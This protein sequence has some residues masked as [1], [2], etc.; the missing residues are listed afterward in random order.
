[1]RNRDGVDGSHKFT[2]YIE[3]PSHFSTHSRSGEFF[4]TTARN[5]KWKKEERQEGCES[6]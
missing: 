4:T 3:G 5:R 6:D 1:M 2:A